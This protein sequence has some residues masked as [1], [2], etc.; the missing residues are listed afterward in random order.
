[1][2]SSRFARDPFASPIGRTAFMLLIGLA[3]FI[4]YAQTHLL[5]D[6]STFFPQV[7]GSVS[8]VLVPV[9]IL[10]IGGGL[11][12]LLIGRL[13]SASPT[14]STDP[15][16]INY[17]LKLSRAERIALEATFGLGTL[18][19]LTLLL[20]LIGLFTPMDLR[21]FLM[22]VGVVAARWSVRWIADLVDS[23]RS[24][25]SDLTVWS[26]LLAIFCTFMVITALLKGLAPALAWDSFVYHL[27]IPT[28][29]LAIGRIDA[30]ADNPF[31]GFAQSTEMIYSLVLAV[32]GRDTAVAP[33]HWLYGMLALLAVG[34][35]VRRYIDQDGRGNGRAFGWFAITILLSAFSIWLYMASAYIDLVTM[36]YGVLT[37]ITL[38]QWHFTDQPGRKIDWLI[39]TGLCL[40]LAFTTKYPT[41]MLAIAAVVFVA[42]YSRRAGLIA[43]L[44]AISCMA[45]PAVIIAGGWFAKD[46]L[47]YGNP[48]YP[49]LIGGLNWNS[50]RTDFFN[51][52]GLGYLGTAKFIDVFTLPLSGTLYGI[53]NKTGFGA[54]VGLWLFMGPI[55]F[56][57]YGA[58][59][60]ALRA[61]AGSIFLFM[62]PCWLLWAFVMATTGIG[63]QTRMMPPV[64]GGMAMLGALGFY[65]VTRWLPRP[66]NL[67]RF[68]QVIV[69]LSLGVQMINVVRTLDQEHT[70]TYLSGQIDRAT[71][72]V[73]NTGV[74][75]YVIQKLAT[76]PPQA[77][78]LFLWEPRGYACPPVVICTSDP[79]VDNW[80]NRIANGQTPTHI[81]SLWQQRFDYVLVYTDGYQFEMQQPRRDAPY[82][83]SYGQ[84][85]AHWLTPIWSGFG[86]DLYTWRPGPGQFATF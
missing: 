37:V 56:P 14:A 49:Y 45:I 12:R 36:L 16:A 22:I 29:Y 13:T 66:I 50:W 70:L 1:M 74:Y 11:G 64:F 86:Y 55:V 58:L 46:L 6:A 65:G 32:F 30:N 78:V 52:V 4:L 28:H 76:L 24:A 77:R 17:P 84:T 47:L 27:P 23:V 31:F 51:D 53:L 34:G 8:D 7:I 18:S 42:W 81:F 41:A 5:D 54:D 43:I 9:L 10:T 60:K 75:A 80:A 3:V 21:I 72:M 57:G 26:A 79:I 61:L 48:I 39:L 2:R 68:V 62:I 33:M 85:Q 15:D 20:G 44:R 73:D 82:I 69:A 83:A 38:T 19:L 25:F 40:G 67:A 71:F 63:V 35:F 59:P